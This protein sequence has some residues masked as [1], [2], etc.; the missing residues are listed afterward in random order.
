M[1]KKFISNAML[2]IIMDK[3]AK[4]KYHARKALKQ[5][6]TGPVKSENPPVLENQAELEPMSRQELIKNAMAV[7]KEKSKVLDDL[8]INDRQ[9]LHILAMQAMKV[10]AD[11]PR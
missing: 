9:R 1:I 7:H 4:E 5:G 3:Q 6:G 2:S 8:T 11:D 10:K